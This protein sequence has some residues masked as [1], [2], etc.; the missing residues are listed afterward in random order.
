MQESVPFKPYPYQQAAIE[1]LTDGLADDDIYDP[2]TGWYAD[3]NQLQVMPPDAQF[4]E[5][6]D[7]ANQPAKPASQ[8]KGAPRHF[9]RR[10]L[11]KI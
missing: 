3:R 9:R 11:R 5:F 7:F 2:E 6:S 8:K 1:K 10:R 4:I